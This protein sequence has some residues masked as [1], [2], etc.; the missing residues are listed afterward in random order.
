MQKHPE[1]AS[2]PP[3]LVSVAVA[4]GALACFEGKNPEQIG[5]YALWDVREKLYFL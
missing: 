1:T 2:F 4:G 5:L 3:V